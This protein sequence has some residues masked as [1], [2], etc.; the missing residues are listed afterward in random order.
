MSLDEEMTR[1]GAQ[2]SNLRRELRSSSLDH[3]DIEAALAAAASTHA[4]AAALLKESQRLDDMIN[5]TPQAK[6]V[7]ILLITA[8]LDGAEIEDGF[9][10]LSEMISDLMSD[11]YPSAREVAALLAALSRVAADMACEA[12]YAASGD[13]SPDAGMTL[14]RAYLA[15]AE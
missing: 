2:L 8:F 12:T 15:P 1:L 6:E 9:A 5:V 3:E 4:D 13:G 10:L 14:L 7:A 11:P